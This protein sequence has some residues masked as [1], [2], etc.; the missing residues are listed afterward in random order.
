MLRITQKVLQFAWC[1]AW[2]DETLV[3]SGDDTF[4]PKNT[5][6]VAQRIPVPSGTGLLSRIHGR[7]SHLGSQKSDQ[8]IVLGPKTDRIIQAEPPTEPIPVAAPVETKPQPAVVEAKPEL[9]PSSELTAD[10]ELRALQNMS[11]KSAPPR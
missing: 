4:V 10:E 8:P 5:T 9:L 7:N 2:F 11:Q 1:I 6:V 3:Y